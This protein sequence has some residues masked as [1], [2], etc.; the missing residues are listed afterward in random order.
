[1]SLLSLEGKNLFLTVLGVTVWRILVE[2]R[3]VSV[4]RGFF[5]IPSCSSASLNLSHSVRISKSTRLFLYRVLHINDE[6][7]VETVNKQTGKKNR[8]LRLSSP[9]LSRSSFFFTRWS[10]TSRVWSPI[11]KERETMRR[12]RSVC[13]S[14]TKPIRLHSGTSQT[15]SPPQELVAK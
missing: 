10:S 11:N 3:S 9:S 2:K 13:I 5:F 7:G 12:R 8:F 1:M 14:L 6:H 15:Q 4:T